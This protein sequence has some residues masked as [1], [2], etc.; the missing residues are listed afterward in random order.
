MFQLRRQFKAILLFFKANK[1]LIE[2]NLQKPLSCVA[3]IL[4]V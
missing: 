1:Q 4:P 3:N 2:R